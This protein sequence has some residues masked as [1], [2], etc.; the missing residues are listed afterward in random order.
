MN[1]IEQASLLLS[2]TE[3]RLRQQVAEAATAGDYASVVQLAAWART[4]SQLLSDT[5]LQRFSTSSQPG[6]RVNDTDHATFERKSTRAERRPADQSYPKFFREGDR[7]VRVA[8]SKREKKEYE[9]KA[10]SSVLQ[11]L[12]ATI[13]EKAGDG[14]I[15]SM[16]QLLPIYET[17]GTEAPSYQAY[18]GLALLKHVGLID[19]HGRQGYSLPRPL[20]FKSAVDAVWRNLPKE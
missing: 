13:A 8:W 19:Q 20:E 2:S 14:Q 10:P 5:P 9:H 12:S 15:F 3:T 7:L 18:V 16:N 4:I 1:V 6:A 17:D 11:T